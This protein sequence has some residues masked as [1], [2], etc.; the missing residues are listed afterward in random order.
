MDLQIYTII[1]I[2]IAIFI[3]II[4]GEPPAKIHPV[5]WMG[6]LID[7]FKNF[8][9]KYRNKFSGILLTLILSL[10]FTLATYVLLH[11]LVFNHIIYIIVSALILSTTFAIRALF[12]SAEGVKNDLDVNIDKARRTM[13]FLVSRNTDELS[14]SEIISA[15]IETLTENITDSVIAPLFYTFIFSVPGAVFYRVINTLDAMVGYRTRENMEIGWFPAKTDDVL[16]YIPARLTGFLIVIAAAFLRMDW[17]NAYKIM[18]R[19]GRNPESPNSGYPMAAAAG[20][21]GVK[22]TKKDHYEIGDEIKVLDTDRIV[23]AV[24]LSKVSVALFLLSASLLFAVFMLYLHFIIR[25]PK[26]IICI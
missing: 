12:R 13:S 21:L 16:N 20:A 19:D 5:V 10:I 23:K 14:K 11:W 18:M 1:I 15:A 24:I 22:L 17:R 26:E 9:I 7:Y 3:D 2:F 25:A 8:L 6:K 4:F